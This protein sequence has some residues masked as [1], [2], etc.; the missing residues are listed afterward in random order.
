MARLPREAQTRERQSRAKDYRPPELLEAPDPKNPDNVH[1]WIR[2]A[3]RNEDDAKNISM[4]RRDGW[5][6]VRAD[7]YPE[8]D[9][10]VHQDGKFD[11]IIGVGDLA[12]A[13]NS[14]ENVEKRQA[15]YDEQTRIRESA[16]DNDLLKAEHPSM[17]LSR[18]R[19]SDV[20]HGQ[21]RV[22]LD[23]DT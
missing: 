7:E 3:I 17:P 1:R 14:R 5:E 18:N 9:A 21:R 4:Q 8:F 16:V 12:L 11:G 13:V 2:V 22:R 10:P 6:F 19:R 15:Y 23:G 20:I